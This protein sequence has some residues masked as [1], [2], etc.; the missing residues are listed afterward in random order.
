MRSI[1]STIFLQQIISGKL[2]LFLIWIHNLY[3]LFVHS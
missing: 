3:Y 1:T 2:L